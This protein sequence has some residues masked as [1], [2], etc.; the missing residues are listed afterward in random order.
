MA[1]IFEAA[2]DVK[3]KKKKK[4]KGGKEKELC[5]EEKSIL[6]RYTQS[7]S[8]TVNP[9]FPFLFRKE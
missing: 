3:K 4:K 8:A 6:C 7:P 5:C 1:S 2:A 9:K